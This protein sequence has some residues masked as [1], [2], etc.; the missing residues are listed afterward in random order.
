MNTD[1]ET[2]NQF[3]EDTSMFPIPAEKANHVT[4]VGW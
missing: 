3:V 2:E 4:I 1:T